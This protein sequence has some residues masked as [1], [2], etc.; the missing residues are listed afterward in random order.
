M[1][2]DV[3]PRTQLSDHEVLIAGCWPASATQTM[4]RAEARRSPAP[5]A[6]LPDGVPKQFPTVEKLEAQR[7]TSSRGKPFVRNAPEDARHRHAIF[8]FRTS[9]M[10]L[11]PWSRKSI[12]YPQLGAR[13]WGVW[14]A[15]YSRRGVLGQNM[16]RNARVWIGC[17]EGCWTAG[18]HVDLGGLRTG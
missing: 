11:E 15:R 9:V 3:G 17:G 16:G 8:R 4:P 5:H 7:A 14:N 12:R 10:S 2:S 1:G 13:F 18:P 6:G